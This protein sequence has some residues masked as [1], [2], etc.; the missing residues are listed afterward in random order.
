MITAVGGGGV[1]LNKTNAGGINYSDKWGKKTD[2]NGSYFFSDGHNSVNRHTV[3]TYTINSGQVYTEDNSSSGHSSGHRFNLRINT[4]FD[5]MNS[6]LFTPQLS[7]SRNNT[8]AATN[9]NT[10]QGYDSLNQTINGTHNV[11]TNYTFSGNILLRHKFH[12]KGRTFSLSLNGNNNSNDGAN[13]HTAENTYYTGAGRSDTFN[14]KT[15][16]SQASWTLSGNAT[17]TEP[18]GKKG[19]VKLEYNLSWQPSQSTRNTYDFVPDSGYAHYDSLFSN[20]FNSA[21]MT[22]KAGASYQLHTTKLEWSL[23]TNYQLTQLRSTQE[24]P[25]NFHLSQ[26]FQNVLPVASLNYKIT[27]SKNLRLSY[28]TST[29]APSVNQLQNVVNNTDPLHLYIGNPSLKQTYRHNVTLRYNATAQTAK[30]SFSA[31]INASIAQH[32]VASSTF[33]ADRDT[34]IS[35]DSLAKGSQLTTPVNIEGYRSVNGNVNY[36][37]PLA[38]IKC[39]AN[40]A[41]NSSYSHVP[42]LINGQSGFQTS[43]NSGLT[44]SLNSNIS[45]AVDFSFST[46]ANMV[47]NANPIYPALNTTYY[48][49]GIRATINVI[50]L[51]SIVFNTNISYT[52]NSGLSAGYNKNYTLWNMSIGKKILKKHKGDIRLSAF[53][54]LN[55]NNNIQHTISDIYIQDTRSNILQRYFLLV[56]TCKLSEFKPT[57]KPAEKPEPKL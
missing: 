55:Q 18:V 54:I 40:F 7:L 10:L 41:F 53:D 29:K 2:V 46:N 19:V 1:G 34:S 21:S 49:E 48:S 57:P 13:L 36:S 17:Y 11:T 15:L 37:M 4:N 9:G 32:Y 38:F 28:T 8:T 20:D 16:Q 33:I 45:E 26:D 12:K 22:H 24:Q 30:T 56:F 51:K 42:V 27:K 44:F 5:S 47:S 35:G 50:F 14:Q 39:H 25:L 52:A 3:K 23:G 43:T 31:S 6:V